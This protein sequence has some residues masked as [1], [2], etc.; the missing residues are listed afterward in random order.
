[1][2]PGLGW[3]FLET[4]PDAHTRERDGFRPARPSNDD[5]PDRRVF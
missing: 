2:M 5:R 1:M 3:F 4:A